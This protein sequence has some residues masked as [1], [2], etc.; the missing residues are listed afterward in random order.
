[1]SRRLS[2]FV[3]RPIEDQAPAGL[4]TSRQA[5]GRLGIKPATLYTYVSRGL[6]R[7]VTGAR[8]RER[9]YVA[10]DVER[11]AAKAEAR[12]GHRA[13]AAG[14]LRF[15]DPV[16]DTAITSAGPVTL[17]YRGQD[18]VALADSGTPFENVAAL[19]WGVP[20]ASAPWPWPK[21]NL[22]RIR[23]ASEPVL[24]RLAALLPRLAAADVGR[25]EHGWT[26]EPIRAMRITRAFAALVGTTPGPSPKPV[27]VSETLASRFACASKA[28]AAINAA[29]ILIADHELNVSTFAARV[30]ASGG[31]DLYACMGAGLYAFGGPRHGRA[32]SAIDALVREVGRPRRAKAAVRARFDRGSMMPGFAR[33][34]VYAYEDPR[35]A[36]LLRWAERLARPAHSRL[37]VLLAIHDASLALGQAPMTV[38]AGLLA[39]AYALDLGADEAT[40][41][42]CVGRTVGW[43]GHVFEQR[44]AGT[45][46]RPRARYVGP[47]TSV[48]G[49]P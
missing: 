9:L 14:A 37:R 27:H 28:E 32:S 41:M 7:R 30:A 47:S 42:F 16:L 36:P 17:R 6:I 39:L 29:L 12:R 23:D 13:V 35:V 8:K 4:M 44:A 38:D 21:A 34:P 2:R 3:N 24:W 18:A 31:A 11:V 15:G 26:A 48:E 40:A 46:L 33:H 20:N 1:M 22:L 25:D 43:A 19:L 45:L 49:E 10:D 5:C